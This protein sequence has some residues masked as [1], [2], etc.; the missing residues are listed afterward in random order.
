MKGREPEGRPGARA[1]AKRA[2]LEL[3]DQAL[4]AG[5][6]RP[7]FLE[8]ADPKSDNLLE[9]WTRAVAWAVDGVAGQVAAATLGKVQ[10]QIADAVEEALAAEQVRQS[11]QAI[12]EQVEILELEQGTAPELPLEPVPLPDPGRPAEPKPLAQVELSELDVE[13]LA[14]LARTLL[15]GPDRAKECGLPY[16]PELEPVVSRMAEGTLAL[17]RVFLG[18]TRIG[19]LYSRSDMRAARR[20]VGALAGRDWV[21]EAELA[22]ETG[23]DLLYLAKYARL[24]SVDL[25]DRGYLVERDV[26]RD[27]A[28][29]Y[30]I[31]RVVEADQDRPGAKGARIT[32]IKRCPVCGKMKSLA[33]FNRD[34]N[35]V[36]GRR[37][38]C[39]ECTKK[40]TADRKAAKQQAPERSEE[41]HA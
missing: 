36:D 37:T 3:V 5:A 16:S 8:R 7:A 22:E 6:F 29:S 30:R 2:V 38:E 40:Q 32:K 12:L 1:V 11:E 17:A 18:E 26:D 4:D 27:G 13:G 39:R 34:K 21:G 14:H 25:E 35:R 33:Y 15:E 41:S 10:R 9:S 31:H 24:A 23:V 20:V 28:A 19:A